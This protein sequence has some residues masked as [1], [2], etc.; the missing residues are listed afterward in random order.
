MIYD[1]HVACG[2]DMVCHAQEALEILPA[3]AARYSIN[4]Y[5]VVYIKI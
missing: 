3:I 5:I 4:Q 1:V 2:M